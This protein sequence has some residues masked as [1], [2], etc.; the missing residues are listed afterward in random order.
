M[1]IQKYLESK[2]TCLIWY[3]TCISGL[4]QYLIR[5]LIKEEKQSTQIQTYVNKDFKTP[6]M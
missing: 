2:D 6:Y 4:D 1:Y 5:W 3:W